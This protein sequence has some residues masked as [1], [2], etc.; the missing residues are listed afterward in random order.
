MD[1]D[2]WLDWN[3]SRRCTVLLSLQMYEWTKGAIGDLASA[4]ISK[5]FG[6]V[7]QG[8]KNRRPRDIGVK[9]LWIANKLMITFPDKFTALR[10]ATTNHACNIQGAD[11]K[12]MASMS[13]QDR[14]IYTEMVVNNCQILPF[15]KHT[16]LLRIFSYSHHGAHYDK[17]LNAATCGSFVSVGNIVRVMNAMEQHFRDLFAKYP[18]GFRWTSKHA[19]TLADAGKIC[20]SVFGVEP[21]FW[22]MLSSKNKSVLK[23]KEN[24]GAI[25]EEFG[26]LEDNKKSL[27]GRWEAF[28]QKIADAKETEK[29]TSGYASDGT[30]TTTA[31]TVYLDDDADAQVVDVQQGYVVGK[32]CESINLAV[33]M[34]RE[35]NK[36]RKKK[37]E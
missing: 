12:D 27:K 17:D 8:G 25:L 34:K 35:K 23:Y 10:R 2:D 16:A 20:E 36:H 7:P 32:I 14:Q 11:P 22:Y 4:F 37:K 13:E 33:T 15:A 21:I 24:R 19:L 30:A 5:Q 6:S 29:E 26:S 31:E 1:D 3:P 18:I 9:L 28:M